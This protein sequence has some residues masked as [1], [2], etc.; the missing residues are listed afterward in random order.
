MPSPSSRALTVPSPSVHLSLS[1]RAARTL[2]AIEEDKATRRQRAELF[3]DR[4][5]SAADGSEDPV[6]L[7]D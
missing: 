2:A 6:A 1:P 5:A 3:A 7:E 4:D